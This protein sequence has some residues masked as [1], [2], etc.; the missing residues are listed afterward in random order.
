MQFNGVVNIQAPQEKVWESL[1]D[2]QFVSQCAPGL[3]SVEVIEPGKQFKAVASVGFGS[4]RVTFHNDVEFVELDPP[5]YAKMKAHGK[6][7]GSGVEITSE[8]S[9]SSAEDGTTELS[10]AADIVVVGTIA[11]LA[12]RII[13]SMTRSLTKAFFDCIKGKIEA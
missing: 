12:S 7:P 13:G 5:N 6:A 8:M 2:P 9:L 1:I 10:W 4:V 11:G 3:Q